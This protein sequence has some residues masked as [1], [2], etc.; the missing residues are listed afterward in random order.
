VANPWCGFSCWE[1]AEEEP[2]ISLTPLRGETLLVPDGSIFADFRFVL[3]V[4]P[5]GAL[6][7][8]GTNPPS[9]GRFAAFAITPYRFQQATVKEMAVDVLAA[10]V[11]Q[12]G[13]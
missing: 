13:G 12:V 1:F 11:S 6:G 7:E 8:Q 3:F 5:C 4:P 2:W 9:G 10:A